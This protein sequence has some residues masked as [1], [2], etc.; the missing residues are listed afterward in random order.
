MSE[1]GAAYHRQNRVAEA[2]EIH[3]QA[4]TDYE[5]VLGPMH[6]RTLTLLGH[7]AEDLSCQ[8]RWKEAIE[9]QEK[10]LEGMRS[11]YGV[12]HPFTTE[13]L[14]KLEALK[15]RMN[16]SSSAPKLAERIA[17]EPTDV[18]PKF[19]AGPTDTH[20]VA[21]KVSRVITEGKRQSHPSASQS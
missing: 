21:A 7:L 6:P 4:L 18:I 16:D 1:L 19:E 10:A 17:Q 15:R 13:G 5:R 2:I 11:T 9:F 20:E 12:D 3:T 8:G 14:Q